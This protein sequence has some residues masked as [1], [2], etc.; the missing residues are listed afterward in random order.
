[1]KKTSGEKTVR[2]EIFS[3]LSILSIVLVFAAICGS[4]LA[5]ML[6]MGVLQLPAFLS[7]EKAEESEQAP[8]NDILSV[9]HKEN[10]SGKELYVPEDDSDTLKEL[11]TETVSSEKIYMR[12][13]CVKITDDQSSTAIFD[14]W[15]LDE[16]FRVVEYD[17]SG[18]QKYDIT[19]DGEIIVMVNSDGEERKLESMEYY[20]ISPMPDMAS[21][22]SENCNVI[23]TN[24]DDGEFEAILDDTAKNEVYDIKISMSDMRLISL[25]QFENN[26]P[27][28][29]IEVLL[30]SDKVD[31][32]IFLQ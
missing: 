9:L 19:F 29:I 17:V 3:L 2:N 21:V 30:I 14:V 32:S 31:G 6:Q 28:L 13:S 1:M 15:R 8:S 22:M 20:D 27:S 7:K 23:Y 18:A 12:L 26:S 10:S 25:K 16:K 11:I 5:L 24:S 4:V